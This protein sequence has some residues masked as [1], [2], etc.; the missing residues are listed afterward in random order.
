MEG[1]R[2]GSRVAADW[3]EEAIPDA[4]VLHHRS[5]P[6]QAPTIL[7]ISWATWSMRARFDRDR[8]RDRDRAN[9][10]ISPLSRGTC[11]MAQEDASS[12]TADPPPP[13]SWTPFQDCA[14]AIRRLSTTVVH[15]AFPNS[16]SA[17][18]GPGLL[19]CPRLPFDGRRRGPCCVS[20]DM[21]GF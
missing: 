13:E 15:C 16:N 7:R 19:K 17:M 2:P 11:Q 20:R 3:E 14:V 18:D 4:I 5:P 9:D 8:D 1:S 21:V 6:A 12:P 10:W